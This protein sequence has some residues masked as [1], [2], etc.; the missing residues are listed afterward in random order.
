MMSQEQMRLY[1]RERAVKSG[2]HC[3]N[4]ICCNQRKISTCHKKDLY[5]LYNRCTKCKTNWGKNIIHC[6]CCGKRLRLSC[7]KK[8]PYKYQLERLNRIELR[9][10]IE[11]KNEIDI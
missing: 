9:L 11:S 4:L 8:T 6:P 1:N 7:R 10:D 5:S 3:L 2:D